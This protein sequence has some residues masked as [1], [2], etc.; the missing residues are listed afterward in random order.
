MP[1]LNHKD[2]TIRSFTT[3]E[4]RSCAKFKYKEYLISMSQIFEPNIKVFNLDSSIQY[5]DFESVEFAIAFV[6]S[7]K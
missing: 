5:G 2:F 3:V 6:D 4:T 7:R 1:Q